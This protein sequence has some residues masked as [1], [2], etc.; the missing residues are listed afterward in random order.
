M[1]V[2]IF[3]NFWAFHSCWVYILEINDYQAGSMVYTWKYIMWPDMTKPGF[4]THSIL[5]HKLSVISLC[6][7]SL[8]VLN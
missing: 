7:I 2:A 3:K 6:A 4:H 5:E 8:E 1:Y